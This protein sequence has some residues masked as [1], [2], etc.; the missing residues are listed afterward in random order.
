MAILSFDYYFSSCV[1]SVV[2]AD[3]IVRNVLFLEWTKLMRH[4]LS[5]I[6]EL[7]RVCASLNVFCF[8]EQL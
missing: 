3:R 8:V 6:Q 4:V 2:S 5:R 7:L 1:A